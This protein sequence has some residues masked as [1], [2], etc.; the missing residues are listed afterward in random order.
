MLRFFLFPIL[1]PLVTCGVL[2]ET[3][4]DL[5]LDFSKSILL[6]FEFGIYHTTPPASKNW[7]NCS[8]CVDCDIPLEKRPLNKK[9]LSASFEQC[10]SSIELFTKLELKELSR[11]AKEDAETWMS[12]Y[13]QISN[14][15]KVLQISRSISSTE[16][17]VTRE[18]FHAHGIDAAETELL[19]E[20]VEN[21]RHF[22]PNDKAVWD[23]ERE[24]N[25]LEFS[26]DPKTVERKFITGKGKGLH[27]FKVLDYQT[28]AK[29]K[30]GV[31][32]KDVIKNL[33][34]LSFLQAEGY[35]NISFN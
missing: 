34:E 30:E 16:K 20:A 25:W 19:L 11:V 10:P 13:T 3:D 21:E 14:D 24:A 15:L 17:S 4:D 18:T 9:I 32:V 31:G 26:W 6:R 22:P 7:S 2:V 23:P 8:I 33:A 27:D 28:T 5:V 35:K 1:L 29:L 12:V